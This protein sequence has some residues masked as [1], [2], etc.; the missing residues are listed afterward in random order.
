MSGV[1]GATVLVG[2]GVNVLVGDGVLLAVWVTVAVLVGVRVGVWVEVALAVL[3]AVGVGP[4]VLHS[5]WRSGSAYRWVSK[6]VGPY[7]TVSYGR[8]M[9]FWREMRNTQ[10]SHNIRESSNRA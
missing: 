7:G 8:Q 6:W 10:P 1:G 5:Q 9:Q 4:W 3:V 2:M